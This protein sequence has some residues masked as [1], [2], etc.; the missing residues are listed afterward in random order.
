MWFSDPL[1]G[2][3]G[4]GMVGGW[5]EDSRKPQAG[6][7]HMVFQTLTTHRSGIHP[8]GSKADIVGS[9]PGALSSEFPHTSYMKG[10]LPVNS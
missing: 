9:R 2:T 4:L 8:P 1:F 6:S 10:A 5:W 3:E 7:D